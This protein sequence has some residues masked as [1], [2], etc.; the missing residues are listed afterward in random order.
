MFTGNDPITG[1]SFDLLIESNFGS[2][3]VTKDFRAKAQQLWPPVNSTGSP[4]KTDKERLSD[5]VTESSFTCH[6]RLIADAYA[7]KVYTVEYA[8]NKARHGGDQSTTFFNPLAPENRNLAADALPNKLA[9]QSYF[10]S[11]AQ[12]GSPNTY[13]NNATIEWPLTSG[14]D[15]PTV[16]N[17]LKFERPVGAQG[18]SIGDD[19]GETKAH[20]GLLADVQK[21][22]QTVITP[23][24]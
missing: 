4:Y 5:Y 2:S 15:G 1:T 6:N 16:K 17:V 14:F 9:Y 11:L 13:R 22:L 18:F 24:N 21:A 19:P 3:P 10:I 23:V 12:T 7:G 8:I 20:C